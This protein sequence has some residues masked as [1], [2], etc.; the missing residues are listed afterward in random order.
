MLLSVS[1]F[2]EYG[3]S[4]QFVKLNAF[5]HCTAYAG[6]TRPTAVVK[7]VCIIIREE[8]FVEF[9]NSCEPDESQFIALSTFHAAAFTFIRPSVFFVRFIKIAARRNV[10]RLFG[11]MKR[12]DKSYAGITACGRN[13]ENSE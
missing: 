13:S 5:E 2:S 4:R 10:I 8:L 7:A 12:H 6:A 9:I 3:E 11:D 1:V